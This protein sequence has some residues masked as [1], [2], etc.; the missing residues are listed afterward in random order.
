MGSTQE[1]HARLWHQFTK[2]LGTIGIRQDVF[3][4]SFTRSQQNKTIG[5]FTMALQEGRFSSAAHE[6]LAS[7]TI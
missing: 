6:T 3:L 7:G 2:Y 5:A 4:D 1:N